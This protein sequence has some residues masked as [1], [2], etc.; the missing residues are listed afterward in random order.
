M[1]FSN[2]NQYLGK[3][4]RA[5]DLYVVNHQTGKS[6]RL[7]FEGFEFQVGLKERDFSANAL[8]RIR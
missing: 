1:T 8:K 3:H 5:H 4:W 7:T 2:F 6:T